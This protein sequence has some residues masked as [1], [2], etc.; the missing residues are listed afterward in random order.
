MKLKELLFK[1]EELTE[2]PHD[3]ERYDEWGII[4]PGRGYIS[5]QDE[6]ED[7][8]E[9]LGG[10]SISHDSLVDIHNINRKEPRIE[11][12]NE[13]DKESIF[14]FIT[15]EEDEYSETIP[16]ISRELYQEL[17]KVYRSIPI[18]T[19]IYV[20]FH[21]IDYF[22]IGEIGPFNNEDKFLNTIKKYVETPSGKKLEEVVQIYGEWGVI[23]EDEVFDGEE[24]S[25]Y[26]YGHDALV[27]QLQ[28]EGKLK[29]PWAEFWTMIHNN[30]FGLRIA[31][32]NGSSLTPKLFR[33]LQEALNGVLIENDFWID[34]YKI[35]TLEDGEMF[36]K[37]NKHIGPFENFKK[38]FGE[39][40][41]FVVGGNIQETLQEVVN[42]MEYH[43]EWGILTEKG[44][45]S[46]EPVSD[47]D[48]REFI[49]RVDKEFP[50]DKFKYY[51]SIHH[52]L[53]LYFIDKG[54]MTD[55]EEYVEVY[56]TQSESELGLRFYVKDK[57][58]DESPIISRA[59]MQQVKQFVLNIHFN[60]SYFLASFYRMNA[61]NYNPRT[62]NNAAQM[63]GVEEVIEQNEHK[64]IRELSKYVAK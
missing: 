4:V 63:W 39:L 27:N 11:Y 56:V 33:T 44:Y 41:K 61:Y 20:D 8:F 26:G 46:A 14:R 57:R 42:A 59:I 43:A 40:R 18:S 2:A 28:E 13:S 3:F 34:L 58:E 38:A 30:Q 62:M 54:M 15:T 49:T 45:L 9:E 10:A 50:N 32:H 47:Q 29:A 31:S 25:E 12:A 19:P 23:T 37:Y 1:A 16:P 53:R 21:T 17:L 22:Y 51:S 60:I 35:T 5:G 7:S 36:T 6:P 55:D 24:Y 64:Y 48:F 52:T